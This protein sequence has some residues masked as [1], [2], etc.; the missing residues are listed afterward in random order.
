MVFDGYNM[1]CLS[2][3]GTN[4]VRILPTNSLVQVILFLSLGSFFC[5]MVKVKSALPS[6][7]D[8]CQDETVIIID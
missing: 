3:D 2:I 4:L 8:T 7:Q 6:S 1:I 5:H